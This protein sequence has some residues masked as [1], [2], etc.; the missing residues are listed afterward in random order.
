MLMV[1]ILNIQQNTTNKSLSFQTSIN[2]LSI[3]YGL[4]K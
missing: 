3:T 1:T 2:W 4:L